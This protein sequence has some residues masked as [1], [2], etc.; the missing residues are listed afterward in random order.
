MNK[1]L[2]FTYNLVK[3]T[4]CYIDA[5]IDNVKLRTIKGLSQGTSSLASLLII[6]ILVG[7]FVTVLSLAFVIWLGKVLGNYALSA[8]IVAGV[9]LLII[10]I[11]FLLRKQ[12]FRDKFVSMYADVFFRKEN[13]PL[14]LR[15]Q[16]ALDE[17]IIQTEARAKDCFSPKKDIGENILSII[18]RL[19][20]K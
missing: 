18:L 7:T 16:E 12:L 14:G 5:Q 3:D 20:L 13:K 9:L 11:L 17:A 6:F 1:F 4:R 8:F 2:T 15:D 19:L 10:V